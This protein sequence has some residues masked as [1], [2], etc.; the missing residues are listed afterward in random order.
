VANTRG[1]PRASSRTHLFGIVALF[2]GRTRVNDAVLRGGIANAIANT[3]PTPAIAD[4]ARTGK[5]IVG[6]I[7]DRISVVLVEAGLVLAVITLL[8]ILRRCGELR[9]PSGRKSLC[10]IRADVGALA[11]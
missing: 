6:R 3:L 9:R 8:V 2:R 4:D 7:S 10:Q 5:K 11:A 1:W